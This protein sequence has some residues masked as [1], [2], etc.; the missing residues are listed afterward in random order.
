MSSTNTHKE[1]FYSKLKTIKKSNNRLISREHL[2]LVKK[3]LSDQPQ[4]INSDDDVDDAVAKRIKKRI[5]RNKFTLVNVGAETN[6]VCTLKKEAG[7][8]EKPGETGNS[9]NKV[10]SYLASFVSVISVSGCFLVLPT[11]MQ[12]GYVTVGRYDKCR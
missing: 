4:N 1:Q 8:R 3:Y 11:D 7:D 6:V 2:E 12:L 10:G 9:G 5:K